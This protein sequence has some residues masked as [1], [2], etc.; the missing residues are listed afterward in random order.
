V[1]AV[2][3]SFAAVIAPSATLTVDT[4]ESA[5]FAVV[6]D[7][8]VIFAV[9]TA[10]SAIFAVVTAL[11]AIVSAP[12]LLIVASPLIATPVATFEALPTKIWPEVSE[13]LSL[14]LSCV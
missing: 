14:L 2:A 7:A 4:E 5:I 12:A 1:T 9:V 10:E 13:L 11:F 8:S 6:T 3:A